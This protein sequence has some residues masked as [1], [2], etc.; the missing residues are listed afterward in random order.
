MG[1]KLTVT[2]LKHYII[3]AKHR[4]I[5]FYLQDG[6]L[7][8][9]SKAGAIT[10][11]DK[12]L[13]K[14]NKQQLVNML[15]DYANTSSIEI[16]AQSI[17]TDHLSFSQSRIVFLNKLKGTSSD[18][19]MVIP[20]TVAGYIDLVRLEAS[21]QAIVERHETLRTTY[22]EDDGEF[23][24]LV[25][26]ID[27]V[28]FKLCT[29]YRESYQDEQRQL[30]IDENISAEANYNFNLESELM[31]RAKYVQYASQ[32]GLLVINIHHI[33]SDGWSMEILRQELSTLCNAHSLDQG[34]DMLPELPLCYRDY[35]YWQHKNMHSNDIAKQIAYWS[36]GLSGIPETHALPVKVQRHSKMTRKGRKIESSLTSCT[37]KQ[38]NELAKS[39]QMTPFMLCHALFSL[40]ISR[41][42]H[43]HDIVVGTPLSGRLT[44]SLKNMMGLFVNTVAL[45]TNTNFELVGDFFNHVKEVHIGAQ[46]NQSLPFD[47]VVEALNIDSQ[48][49]HN[50]IFQ[51]LLTVNSDYGLDSNAADKTLVFPDATLTVAEQYDVSLKFELEVDFNI[52]DSGGV[53]SW[54]FDKE[55]FDDEFIQAL[56]EHFHSYLYRLLNATDILHMPLA[57]VVAVL[58]QQ[59]I[60]LT[61]PNE[62]SIKNPTYQCIHSII[63]AQ[64]NAQK[65]KVAVVCAEQKMSYQTLN[66]KANQVA[67]YLREAH[68]VGPGKL[69]G[70]CTRR[71]IDMVIGMLG[72]L[73]AG[74]A[75]VPIDPEYPVERINYMLT[76]SNISTVLSEHCI[77][78]RPYAVDSNATWLALDKIELDG[79]CPC[80]L[81]IE[82]IGLQSSD[83]AYIIYTSGSTGRP[84]GVMVEHRNVHA[85]MTWSEK[86]FSSS[87]LRSVLAATSICFDISVFEIFA[88]LSVGGQVWL[89]PDLLTVNQKNIVTDV[90]LI[91]TVPSVMTAFMEMGDL[92]ESV[93]VVCLVG[94]PV[95][96]TLVDALYQRG[97]QKV[98]D[99]YGPTEDTVY[100]TC[101]LRE[102]NGVAN[103]GYP[104]HNTYAYVLD[105]KR[106]LVPIGAIGTLYL[107]GSG[108]T[109]GY[110][111]QP[112][113]T[114]QKFLPN[115]FTDNDTDRMYN[116]GDLV[117]YR[118]DGTLQYLGRSDEQ[119]KLNGLRI[120]CGEVA[121]Q[122]N[123]CQGVE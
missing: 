37:S 25:K 51:M 30:D 118:H 101:A 18:Y 12:R 53:I 1:S 67:N 9:K 46:S 86:T 47:K 71:S 20:F 36:Q 21:F 34:K 28:E 89:A 23:K 83:L 78:T 4:G 26:S 69:I 19:N 10:S 105:E 82:Y 74:G 75:Y 65:D 57:D 44:P 98:Y 17:K 35:V 33:A 90:S 119:V 6:R 14:E 97:V 70:L 85:L 80:N 24:Q 116:T 109:R 60:R 88:P 45:R 7:K 103:I 43:H 42:S 16:T 114:A 5:H 68:G 117:R 95:K 50:P 55:L 84:K 106:A 104:I 59:K 38:L 62:A 99:L 111:N 96:Q 79:Y 115:P 121:H 107:G 54:Q 122:L 29:E 94:E 113:L 58:E 91:N 61:Q 39:L 40:I 100:S 3:D 15:S 123:R 48:L 110:L 93:E 63:E 32:V 73:K 22:Y 92:P 41:Y 77:L 8:S 11:N 108:V 120:E 2:E 87:G 72:I 112:E 56:D 81:D 102:L 76:D 13:V 64:V 27:Q 49:T 66:E 31:I 52:S